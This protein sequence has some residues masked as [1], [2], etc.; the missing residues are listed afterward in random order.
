MRFVDYDASHIN[1]VYR[2][3]VGTSLVIWAV[4]GLLSTLGALCYAELGTCISRSGGDYAYILVAFGPML[5]FLR[6]WIALFIIRPTTQAIIALTFAQYAAKPFFPECAPPDVAVRLLA[7]ACLC[8]LTA[9][10]CMSTRVT[11][12][13]QDI[14]TAAKLMA[15]VA[16]IL[17]GLYYM[18]AGE[19][20]AG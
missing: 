18:G 1:H 8:L 14:F 10:N 12:K 4:C 3:S 20:F 15:L 13:I 17:S 16:I 6:M 11:M 9:I 5:A 19:W 2:R 7:C